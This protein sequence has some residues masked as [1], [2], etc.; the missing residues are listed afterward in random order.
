[1][2][3]PAAKTTASETAVV[4]QSA[5]TQVSYSGTPRGGDGRIQ[6]DD[7]VRELANPV[8]RMEQ[9]EEMGNDDAVQTGILARRQEIC[10]ANW[11]LSTEDSS[12]LGR[13]ILEFTEDN[14][15]PFLD[16]ILRLLGGGGMQYGFGALEPVYQWSDRAIVSSIT[17]GRK[18]K[19][20]TR[21]GE[22]RIYIRKLAHLRQTGVETFKIA[23]PNDPSGALAGDLQSILQH[24]YD[25]VSFKQRTVPAEK[26]LLWVYNQQGDDYFGTPPTRACYKAWKIKSQI[27]KLNLLHHDKFAVGMPIAEEGPAWTADDRARLAVF[28][29]AYR[30]GDENFIM[31]PAGGKITIASDD[32]KTS[33][34]MLEWI[35]YYNLA[36]AKTFLT[37]QTE[38]GSTETGAR[39]LGEVFYDQMGGIV[40]ADCEDIANLLNNELIV[41]LVRWNF[42]EQEFYPTFAPSQRV[43]AGSGVAAVLQQLISSKALHPRPEDEAYLRDVFEMPA[44]E[45]K[46]LKDEQG[47]RDAQAKS[48]ADAASGGTNGDAAGGDPS[49]PARPGA[50]TPPVRIAAHHN[51]R[52][53]FS[54]ASAIADGAPTPAVYGKT[55]YRTPEYAAWEY[56]IVKPDV[57]ERELDM[58]TTRTASEVQ[59]VLRLIDAELTR[60]IES[61]ASNGA[62]ALSA[63]VRDIAVPDKLRTQLRKVLL[64][65][66]Q[67]ARTFGK[68][69]VVNEIERQLGP[70]A[71]GPQRSPS[72]FA[73]F[74]AANVDE[75]SD[76][77]LH[78]E[79]EVDRAVEDEIDRR[80]G[81]A[82]A[83]A[84]TALAMT[85]GAAADALAT[86]ASTATKESLISLSPYRTADNVEGVINVGFGIGRSETAAAI[87][88]GNP[89][90]LTDASGGTIDIVAKVYSAVMDL[91]TC[92]ECAKWDGAEFPIDYPE[93]YTGVQA[94]NPR[95]AG[96]IGRCRCIWIYITS[97]EGVPLVPASNGPEPIRRNVA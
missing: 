15:Y 83:A 85:I 57:L 90:G 79:A 33:L 58:Q 2:A 37:Q 53:R 31:H 19:R 30:S 48:I 77:Q 97:R 62:A 34:S 52:P 44:V 49:L 4:P 3:E 29:R 22:R 43:R 7:Y 68:Q 66:A 56:N 12:D 80:E 40:Q 35:R 45:L 92:D 27:E 39:A 63:G 70:S 5:T 36:V 78:L 82:R 20:A 73:R 65:A 86:V 95:C 47:Q 50:A 51:H 87:R 84:R 32:G 89:S 16:K 14:V 91:G 38:L 81:S 17:R 11:Q 94:P 75:K 26:T 41:T 96:G 42:G 6:P 24:V 93:D 9:F 76:E 67:R 64:T 71:I 59:D 46:V 74:L 69:A 55:T 25:G 72:M 10:A 8:T 88:D 21:G 61:L 1:M 28:L 60:Q 54:L 18:V 13:E 23:G